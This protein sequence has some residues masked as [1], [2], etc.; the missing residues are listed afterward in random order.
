MSDTITISTLGPQI[1]GRI[2]EVHGQLEAAIASLEET[3]KAI[4]PSDT[5]VKRRL[6]AGLQRSIEM[7]DQALDHLDVADRSAAG[8]QHA[9]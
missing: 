8:D 9:A 7:I 1:V 5:E 4:T 2:A 3:I 6:T